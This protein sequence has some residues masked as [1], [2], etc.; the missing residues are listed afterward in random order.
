MLGE[1]LS[2]TLIVL[3]NLAVLIIAKF[4]DVCI[5]PVG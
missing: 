2:F 3:V 1:V 5:L 4:E